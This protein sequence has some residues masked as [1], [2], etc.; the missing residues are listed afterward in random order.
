MW[1]IEPDKER[2]LQKAKEGQ[3]SLDSPKEKDGI[4][5]YHWNKSLK[6]NFII[7]ISYIIRRLFLIIPTFFGTTFL[8]F[9]ILNIILMDHLIKK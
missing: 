2:N 5:D 1:W 4:V 7:M 9:W 6:Q 8:V 3:T